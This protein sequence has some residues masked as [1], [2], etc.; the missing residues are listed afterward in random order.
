MQQAAKRL[1]DHKPAQAVPP[2][3]GALK[4]L[5]KA[6]KEIEDRLAQLR[7]EERLDKL[8]KLEARFQE[9]LVRQQ[10]ATASTTEVDKRRAGSETLRRADV[11]LLG[12]VAT[13]EQSLT[14][15]ASQA[16][17]LIRDDGTSVVFPRVVQRMHG[18]LERV[19]KWLSN[20]DTGRLT[21]S[22]QVEIERTLEE[23]I[24]A[25]KEAQK[26]PKSGKP[27]QGK[28]GQPSED[29]L[30]PDNAE[31]KLLRAAQERV[32]RL[33]RE[34]DKQWLA[35]PLDEPGREEIR[36]ISQRQQDISIMTE[37]MIKRK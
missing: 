1:S 29:P 27:K 15:M 17:E 25:L 19:A 31:L 6:L 30:M 16:L 14:E 24:A 9:M 13:E 26:T 33:T 11:I 7:E 23:L 32:N 12:K 3:D 34:F 18:D 10:A 2:A 22:T 5:K 37:E 21:Q 36:R 20:R 4:D 28:L 8:A 35:K